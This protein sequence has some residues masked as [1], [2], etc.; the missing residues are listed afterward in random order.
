MRGKYIKIENSM[1]II[2]YN[3]KQK[4]PRHMVWHRRRQAIQE[5]NDQLQMTREEDPT[6]A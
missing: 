6:G 5:I 3:A 1:N 2:I 4:V